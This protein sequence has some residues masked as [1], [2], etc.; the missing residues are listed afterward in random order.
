MCLFVHACRTANGA[1]E[2]T[3]NILMLCFMLFLIRMGSTFCW[4]AIVGNTLVCCDVFRC[5]LYLFDVLQVLASA[6]YDDSIK[7]YSEDGDDWSCYATLGNCFSNCGR[8]QFSMLIIR[9]PH[10]YTSNRLTWLSPPVFY[11]N[12]RILYS[13]LCLYQLWLPFVLCCRSCCLEQSLTW[14]VMHSHSLN[15]QATLHNWTV[16]SVTCAH[17]SASFSSFL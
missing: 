17:I 16:S 13:V 5:I 3:R 4:C 6:S 15:F 1:R 2:L 9:L 14:A 11:Y 12:G 7:L 8:L 10:P